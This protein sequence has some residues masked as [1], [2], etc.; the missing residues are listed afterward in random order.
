[1][2]MKPD[3]LK[4]LKAKLAGKRAEYIIVEQKELD[5][6][7]ARSAAN[8]KWQAA[9]KQ[10]NTLWLEISALEKEIKNMESIQ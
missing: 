2:T 6:E 8:K 1:M 9:F 7:K 4:T 3:F 5:A 10:E